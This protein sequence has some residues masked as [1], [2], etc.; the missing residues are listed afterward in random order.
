M[1]KRVRH[2]FAA[3]ALYFIL[4]YVILWIAKCLEIFKRTSNQLYQSANQS[5]VLEEFKTCEHFESGPSY[6]ME[7]N[8]Q[9]DS[10][11]VP[12]Q[13]T[14]RIEDP[15]ELTQIHNYIM[16]KHTYYGCQVVWSNCWFDS[17]LLEDFMIYLFNHHHYLKCFCSVDTLPLTVRSKRAAFVLYISVFFIVSTLL[18]D[19]LVFHLGHSNSHLISLFAWLSPPLSK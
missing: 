12:N 10:L 17:G 4:L 11:V 18:E 9:R 16:K 3:Y 6:L 15:D 2:Y 14:N 1:R 13:S 5:K 19:V 7:L 8:N